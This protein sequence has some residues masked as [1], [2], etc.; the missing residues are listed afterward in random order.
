MLN[1]D[2]DV[3]VLN[4]LITTTI[5]SAN[6][7]ERSA[8]DSE[9]GTFATMFREFGSE[10]REAVG[11]LQERVRALGG[12]PNDDGSLKADVHRRF[13]DL[14]TAFTGGSDKAVIEEVE[15]GED[16]IKDKYETALQDE[17]LS[18]ET[19][20]VIERAYQSVRRGHDRASQLKHSMQGA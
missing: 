9:S 12:T 6:G 3:T 4:T 2:H 17:Q 15:R 19:R 20:A 14:K 18:T 7:F 13:V 8:E 16:Y 1:S 11:A 5:D 10:R